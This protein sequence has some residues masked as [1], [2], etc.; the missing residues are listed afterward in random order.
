MAPTS[1]TPSSAAG[2][3]YFVSASQPGSGAGRAGRQGE[4]GSAKGAR[5]VP[6]ASFFVVPQ[7]ETAREIALHP[8]E[9]LTEIIV[10]ARRRAE[11][12]LRSP[13]E[14]SARLAAGHRE[15]GADA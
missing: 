3:A 13:A 12:H 6:A 2:P 10:P 15:R 14:G 4:A 11:R 7:N 5:E 1:I 8:D 9:I